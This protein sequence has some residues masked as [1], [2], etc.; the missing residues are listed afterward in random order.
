MENTSN[1]FKN[2]NKKWMSYKKL[3]NFKFKYVN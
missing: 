2:K 1:G 3:F